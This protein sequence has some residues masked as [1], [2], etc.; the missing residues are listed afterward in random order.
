MI[1][2]KELL[3]FLLMCLHFSSIFGINCFDNATLILSLSAS[4]Y[5]VYCV[6]PAFLPFRNASIQV[7]SSHI[8]EHL[9]DP[10]AFLQELTR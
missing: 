8:I 6:T 4:I 10:V 1:V 5:F 9:P 3:R 7:F 2:S